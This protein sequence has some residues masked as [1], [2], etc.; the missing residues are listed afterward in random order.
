MLHFEEGRCP[1]CQDE[2]TLLVVEQDESVIYTCVRHN[3]FSH[4]VTL[5]PV[6]EATQWQA[7][8]ARTEAS[9]TLTPR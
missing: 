5:T 1:V 7:S 3:Q 4:R 2:A 8:P 6:R 9:H